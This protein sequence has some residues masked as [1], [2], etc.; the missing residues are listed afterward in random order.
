MLRRPLTNDF[1]SRRLPTKRSLQ[2]L[3][4][5]EQMNIAIQRE[6]ARA[7]RNG[8]EFALVLFRA[9]LSSM[10]L[11]RTVLK[12]VRATDDLGWFDDQH[13]AALLPDTSAAGAWRFA[14]QVCM[15]LSRKAPRPLCSVYCYPTKWFSGDDDDDSNHNGNG[16]GK[17]LSDSNGNGHANGNG[18]GNGNGHN[19]N[20][21]GN[22]HGLSRGVEIGAAD[23]PLG[24]GNV[25]PYFLDGVR[26][27][28]NHPAPVHR[29]ENLLVRKPAP[30]ARS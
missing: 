7:D 30:A 11:A 21:N 29:L 17:L 1:N 15:M 13:I 24:V 10:R 8:G 3:L 20:G 9:S 2:S 22:G 4:T 6:S 12:R 28:E 23:R 26:S 14:D 16:N 18:N 19:G 5:S 25:I 27:S